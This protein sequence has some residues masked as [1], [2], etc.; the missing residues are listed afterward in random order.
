VK[1]RALVFCVALACAACGL[2]NQKPMAVPP[3]MPDSA[4]ERHDDMKNLPPPVGLKADEERWGVEQAKEMKRIKAENKAKSQSSGALIP[5]PS[6]SSETA[7]PPE[8]ETPSNR[9][10]V[11]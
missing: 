5:M 4:R 2:R 10:I 1:V 6:P 8:T 7:T 11:K 3:R 9:Y